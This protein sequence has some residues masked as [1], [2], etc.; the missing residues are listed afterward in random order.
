MILHFLCNIRAQNLVLN[1]S[2]ED[3]YN[4]PIITSSILECKNVFNP[5]TNSTSDY[6]NSCAPVY[7]NTLNNMNV[8][9]NWGGFQKAY[10]GNAY[11]GFYSTASYYQE[12]VQIK[13]SLPLISNKVY[14][15]KFYV[16]LANQSS[17]ATSAIDVKFVSDSTYYSTWPLDIYLTPDWSNLKSNFLTDTLNWMPLS[18]S[19]LAKGNEQWVIVGSFHNLSLGDTVRVNNTDMY[20][21][22]YYLD[23]FSVQE[24][25]I[26][27]PNVFTPNGDNA[28]DTFFVDGLTENETIY[29]YNRW[30]VEVINIKGNQAWDGKTKNSLSCNDGVYFCVIRSNQN[31][32]KTEFIQLLR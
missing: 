6:Y 4:C 5:V 25:E 7:T 26:T 9:Y 11:V 18:G 3:R 31:I 22:Y 27:I 24:K 23:G 13:L 20:D 12:Y 1:P 14:N 10:D 15:F 17:I 2:F 19:Y 21:S 29:I 16:S 30:G 8:P 32:I 28:N